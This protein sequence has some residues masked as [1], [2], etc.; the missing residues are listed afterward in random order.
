[1]S[2]NFEKTFMSKQ[3]RDHREEVL[4]EREMGMLQATQ[5]Y[6]EREIRIEKLETAI[7]ELRRE[8]YQKLHKLERELMELKHGEVNEKKKF[9]RKC[10]N[11]SCHGFLSTALKCELCECWACGDCREVKGFTSEEKERHECNKE[12]LESVKLLDKDSKPCPKCAALIF[13]IEGCD[14]MYC[15]ECHTAFS[16]RTLKIESGVIHNPHYFEYQRR[17]NNGAVPRNPLDVQCGRELDNHF[18]NRLMEKFEAPLPKGWKKQVRVSVGYFGNEVRQVVYVSPKGEV[19]TVNPGK[20]NEIVEICR[21]VIHTRHVDVPRFRVADRLTNNL[22]LRVDYMRNKLDKDG[23]KKL[24]QK[25]EKDNLKRGELSEIMGMYVS[26]MTD[27]M[28]RVLELGGEYD[29]KRE[30]NELRK[31]TNSL[32]ESVSKTYNCK[33]YEIDAKFSFN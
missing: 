7:E 4:M 17:L 14:Q 9:V 20:I 24:L 10:P 1:M 25:R 23:L 5:P 16:W 22:Q 31:Y 28:Y 19:H 11:G 3:Y 2:E 18:V 32:L 8:Y 12:I 15:V 29:Y 27:I 13:K 33:K 21:M 6:V 30:M 26:V